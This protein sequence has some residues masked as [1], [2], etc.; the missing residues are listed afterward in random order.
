MR[1][2]QLENRR[3]RR[4]IN[5]QILI[6]NGL[7]YED[8][9][10]YYNNRS[11]LKDARKRGYD[12]IIQEMV[13][14]LSSELPINN[15]AEFNQYFSEFRTIP[16]ER[17]LGITDMLSEYK[18]PLEVVITTEEG[19]E[20]NFPLIRNWDRGVSQLLVDGYFIKT[21]EE[22]GSDK[23][24]EFKLEGIKSIVIREV[25]QGDRNRRNKSGRHFDY[26][27]TTNLDLRK[28]QIYSSETFPKQM[29]HCFTYSLS[30]IG[31]SEDK[32]NSVKLSIIEGAN[33]AKTH[34]TK[35]AELLQMKIILHQ[36]RN[37]NV[38]RIKTIFGKKYEETLE[39]CLYKDHYFMYE[40]TQYNKY[41]IRNYQKCIDNDYPTNIYR[42]KSRISKGF[43]TND[44]DRYKIDSLSLV[45]SLFEQGFFVVGE[46]QH[47]NPKK[48]CINSLLTDN[49]VEEQRLMQI[50]TKKEETNYIFYAD[51]ESD[52]VSSNVHIPILI[53]VVEEE[54]IEPQ[55]FTYYNNTKCLVD[56][57]LSY[58][59]VSV[60]KRGLI[61]QTKLDKIIVY[62]HNLKYDY[63]GLLQ[64][65]CNTS[66]AVVKDNQY[67]SVSVK[68]KGLLIEFRDSYK[69]MNR[70]L[71]DFP[72][73]FGLDKKYS[74]KEAIGYTYYTKENIQKG[75]KRVSIDEYLL[76][77]HKTE[78]YTLDKNPDEIRKEFVSI[79]EDNKKEFDYC[80]GKFNP[81]KYYKYYLK[82]DCLVLQKGIQKYVEIVNDITSQNNKTPLYLH[83]YLTISSLTDAYMKVNGAYE[84]I[85][86]MS[87]YLR[88]FCSRAIQGGRVNVCKDFVKKVIN[89]K[90]DDFDGVSLYPSAIDRC[91]KELGLPIGEGKVITDFSVEKYDYYIVKVLLKK[92]NKKQQNSFIGIKN[93]AG[94]LE[95]VNDVKE[96]GEII[97]VDKITLQDYIEFHQIE[98]DFIDGVYWNQGFNKKMGDL[99]NELFNARLKYK[100]L[101]KEAKTEKEAKGYD[102]LQNVIK[103]MMNSSYGKTIIKTSNK[104][105]SYVDKNRKGETTGNFGKN[106]IY[107]NFNTITKYREVNEEQLEVEQYTID[108][109]Y[110]RCHIG[111]LILSYSKRI[112]NEVMNVAN[113]NDI[114][115]YYQDTDSTHLK[116]K[117]V[118][119]LQKKY[120]EKYN[121]ELIGKN[122]GQFHSDFDLK[123]AVSDIVS[124]RSIFLGKKC[125]ID[126]LESKDKDGNTI[127]G[128]HIRMKGVN[129]AGL[130]HRANEE[131]GGDYFKMYEDLANGEKL[132]F[133]LNPTESAV[134]FE[135]QK[136]GGISTRSV[137]SFER[138]VSF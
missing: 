50:K 39:I 104:K 119:I 77:I 134:S 101:K 121:R 99:I 133:V 46:Y 7:L 96:E 8:N 116:R 130:E 3:N 23:L 110:N 18:E 102:A 31:V 73:I 62:F 97:Y 30:Q 103:L 20:I 111:C 87:G 82:Y 105:V 83:K 100:K 137:G 95:Y 24:S 29:E 57:F 138:I 48:S 85:Y 55:I 86:E 38:N 51:C 45:K 106:Y 53:G 75:I 6:E 2:Q 9:T 49:I 64:K 114:D 37:D 28:Y 19:K 117:D 76:H 41:Y 54:A 128:F 59:K 40:L 81:V 71:A 42:I 47:K 88:E 135:Y 66:Q 27:N 16:E 108:T 84:G 136:C 58:I 91:C 43:E 17:L 60:N 113:D 15:I 68:H 78:K 44:N 36:Y 72:S 124:R 123:G 92:I 26:T 112:M 22:Y 122:L 13:D 109:S 33:L 93:E 14:G 1:N 25:P 118:P 80:E 89:D 52:V 125:Y 21:E 127:T 34:F 61:K 11:I 126:Q 32:I 131:Y 98:Y 94:I 129:S 67:Y 132:K 63:L 90:L 10:F 70:R 115:I 35:I 69:L 79:L 107:S 12:N 5:E 4:R 65:Y 120:N 74:K 56:D